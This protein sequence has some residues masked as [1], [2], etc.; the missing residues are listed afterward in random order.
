MPRHLLIA[1]AFALASLSASGVAA[2]QSTIHS[3]LGAFT[4][5]TQGPLYT[6]TFPAASSASASFYS[7]SGL[8]YAY[9]VTAGSGSLVWRSSAL[10]SFIGNFAAQQSLT[11]TFTSGNVT[12]LGG[13]FFLT[14]SYDVLAAGTVSISL[15]DG[16]STSFVGSSVTDFRGFTTSGAAITSFTLDATSPGLFNS[17]DNFVVGTAA[18]VVPEPSTYLLVAVGLLSTLG[19]A[20]RRNR[21]S[22]NSGHSL[23]D[24]TPRSARADEERTS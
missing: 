19:V 9:T 20:R 24:I 13:N 18:T 17:V 15:S 10:G 4:A 7:F 23:A 16:T 5:A 8:G 22:Y 21:V 6:E 1:S 3:S 14:D 12:A 2:A 11:F